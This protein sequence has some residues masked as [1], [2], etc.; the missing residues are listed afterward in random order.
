MN[1]CTHSNK[2]KI[3]QFLFVKD[4][5]TRNQALSRETGEANTPKCLVHEERTRARQIKCG[6]CVCPAKSQISMRIRTVWSESSRNL[7]D[8]F[9]RRFCMFSCS[10]LSWS[11]RNK[12]SETEKE[13]TITRANKWGMWNK[14]F[15][16]FW[17]SLKLS[18]Q[19]FPL[20]C[21]AF[22]LLPLA[23]DGDPTSVQ[24]RLGR[25]TNVYGMRAYFFFFMWTSAVIIKPNCDSHGPNIS[26]GWKLQ[27]QG[28]TSY[29]W[30][31]PN[32]AYYLFGEFHFLR[33]I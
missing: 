14:S 12:L 26:L 9:T 8:F 18:A 10:Y 29:R 24:G 27:Q 3:S 21:A 33:N 28:L 2:K 20:H 19:L 16:L 1:P 31:T 25:Q 4:R 17:A 11:D 13:E 15:I 30:K 22:G 7:Y 32:A 6:T 23:A 5:P